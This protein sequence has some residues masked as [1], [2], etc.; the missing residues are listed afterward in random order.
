[1]KHLC[2]IPWSGMYN[3][4][5]D[6][7]IDS[8]LN[9]VFSDH[10]TGCQVNADLVGRAFE[11]MNWR[12]VH[13][14]YAE[15]YCKNFAH[16][17]KLDLGFES[18]TSPREYNFTSDICY[19]LLGTA[20]LLR[21]FATVDTPNL[22]AK[23]R[24]NH[25]SRDGFISFY[26]NDLDNWGNVLSWDHNQIGTLLQA[27]VEQESTNDWDGYE[28]YNL[29]SDSFGNGFLDGILFEHGPNMERLAK[30]HDYLEA[31]AKREEVAA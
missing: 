7:A 26:D 17:F 22:R 2:V 18:M 1:M 28:E 15:E 3:T 5:H 13:V 10:D 20:D 30:I 4:L 9:D 6:D 27:F 29:M 8:A 24:A 31:R 16:E 19:G 14:A 21:V 25:T 12:A 11:K 23:V